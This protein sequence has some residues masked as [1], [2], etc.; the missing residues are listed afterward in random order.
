VA[1][2][3]SAPECPVALL[4]PYTKEKNSSSYERGRGFKNLAHKQMPTAKA[5]LPMTV[6]APTLERLATK[7][8]LA[9]LNLVK[10]P[11]G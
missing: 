7:T 5:A 2:K 9:K 6:E 3:A 8:V 1:L 10:K 4:F 11:K